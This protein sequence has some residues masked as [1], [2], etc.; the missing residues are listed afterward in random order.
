MAR[1]GASYYINASGPDDDALR[2]GLAWLYEESQTNSTAGLIAVSTLHTLDNLQRG[3]FKSLF[4]SLRKNRVARLEDVTFHAMTL[5]TGE[6]YSWDG[7][8]LILYGSSKLY[9]A[10][11]SISGSADALLLPWSREEAQTWIDAWSATELGAP[12]APETLQSSLSEVASVALD[13]LTLFVNLSTGLVNPADRQE[14]I[15]T[16]ETLYYRQ[17]V[18]DGETIRQALIQ[19]DWEPRH[20]R[21]AKELFDKIA[22]GSIPKGGSGRADEDLWSHLNREKSD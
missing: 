17:V 16:F 2:L 5:R 10:V 8:I 1:T 13:R 18:V 14:A 20:A 3:T 7:P 11:D 4:E 15:L 9:D 21:E 6:V 12:T 22:R 19:R